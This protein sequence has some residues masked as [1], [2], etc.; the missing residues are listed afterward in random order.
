LLKEFYFPDLRFIVLWKLG[1][2]DV[3]SKDLK[4]A[5]T[6]VRQRQKIKRPSA[7]PCADVNDPRDIRVSGVDRRRD[8]LRIVEYAVDKGILSVQP[9]RSMST[10]S[11]Y[12]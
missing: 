9:V 6:E 1:G 5:I 10:S 8:K 7:S 11:L 12:Q 4:I 2:G 3:T